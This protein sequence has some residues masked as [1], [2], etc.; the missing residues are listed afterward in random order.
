MQEAYLGMNQDVTVLWGPRETSYTYFR[1]FVDVV[2]FPQC[3]P[4]WAVMELDAILFHF[5]TVAYCSAV[6]SLGDD[7]LR[8]IFEVLNSARE[9]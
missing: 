6:S 4:S 3:R 2:V 7:K 8:Y 1:L 9:L 5:L